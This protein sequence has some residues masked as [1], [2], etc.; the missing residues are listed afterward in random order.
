MLR[1]VRWRPTSQPI[2]FPYPF[3]LWP[4]LT[5]V[6]YRFPCYPRAC[7]AGLIATLLLRLIATC[8]LAPDRVL[9]FRTVIA[10]CLHA[11]DGLFNGPPHPW[12]L[13]RVRFQVCFLRRLSRCPQSEQTSMVWRCVNASVLRLM[14]LWR[15]RLGPFV[16]FRLR[17]RSLMRKPRTPSTTKPQRNGNAADRTQ[18]P[19]PPFGRCAI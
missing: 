5:T 6:R 13:G 7:F 10:M 1:S 15:R 4:R 12:H 2:P 11:W 16:R 8:A 18:H 19:T 3:R 17:F 14:R 9:R